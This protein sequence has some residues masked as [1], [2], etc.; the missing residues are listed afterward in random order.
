LKHSVAV[1][2]NIRMDKT[3][4]LS[5]FE[6]GILMAVRICPEPGVNGTGFWQ[7]CNGVGNVYPAHIRSLDTK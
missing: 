1:Q 5:D 2:L 6:H 7:W 4:D 3:S